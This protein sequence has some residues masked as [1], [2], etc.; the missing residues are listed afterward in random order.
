MKKQFQST[1]LFIIKR[2]I[3]IPLILAYNE[4]VFF[5]FNLK[6]FNIM[7]IFTAIFLG[8]FL[9]LLLNVI[10]KYSKKIAFILI[11]AIICLTTLIYI[12]ESYVHVFFN[13]FMPLDMIF[14]NAI[15]VARNY[16]GDAGAAVK[17]NLYIITFFIIPLFIL[18]IFREKLFVDINIK[19]SFPLLIVTLI[20]VITNG[21]LSKNLISNGNDFYSVLY[22]NGLVNA[23]IFNNNNIDTDFDIQD[24][25][26]DSS[27]KAINGNAHVLG[28]N[29]LDFDFEKIN[30]NAKDNLVVYNNKYVNSLTPSNKN[31]YTG[32][33]KGKNVIMMCAES[34]SSHAVTKELTPTLYRLLHNGF[35]FSNAY[36]T[37]I[38]NSTTEGEF[39]LLTGLGTGYGNV[40][41]EK[42][43]GKNNS[44]TFANFTKRAGYNTACFHNGD[45]YYY[46][47]NVTHENI[48][49]DYF[50]ANNKGLY[51]L[52]HNDGSD[53]AMFDAT[54]DLYMD[55]QP[56]SVYYMTYDGH[57]PYNKL[58]KSYALYS[59]LVKGYYGSDMDEAL[60]SYICK[61][62]SFDR[63]LENMINKLDKK[64]ILNDTVIVFA[65]DHY[66]YGLA[67][68]NVESLHDLYGKSFDDKD[69]DVRDTN[70]IVLWSGSL[71][72]DL[73][74]YQKEIKDPVNSLDILP[75]LLNLFGFE[76]DSRF[77]VGRDV[78][79]DTEAIIFWGNESFMTNNCFYNAINGTTKSLDGKNVDSEYVQQRLKIVQDKLKY[80]KYVLSTDYFKYFFDTEINENKNSAPS[81]F[82]SLYK[83]VKFGKYHDEELEW[84]VLEQ[85]T[86]GKSLLLSKNIV[87]TIPYGNTTWDTSYLRKFANSTFLDAAFNTIEQ[88]RLYKDDNTGDTVFIFSHDDFRKYFSEQ[89]DT[90]PENVLLAA[91]ATKYAISKGLYIKNKSGEWYDGNGS[92]WLR[93][94]TSSESMYNSTIEYNGY[95]NSFGY[96]IDSP[97]VGF[98]PAIWVLLD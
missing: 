34:F 58:G 15:N 33:F 20:I 35:Y 12:T 28:Y 16:A 48:G 41:M 51:Q 76:Y 49:Y 31:E 70:G 85:K 39:Q 44:Y 64:G 87:D 6:T 43:I 2:S 86:G 9:F 68:E 83:V 94:S 52:T 91:G 42:T 46:N 65:A 24:N 69:I 19:I 32:L 3:I 67:K 14:N 21:I 30:E 11:F 13:T 61:E 36:M 23:I 90:T 77:F 96:T 88:S 63:A 82:D 7:A 17:G 50:L 56:F 74:P 1:I 62:V 60:C 55:K 40:C 4:V 10:S 93:D 27:N 84:I 26:I 8:F 38:T 37:T 57:V 25:S 66:P 72:N 97:Y 79:S 80:S 92:Y 98:R 89:I 95:I 81:V 22:K 53:Y 73:K 45:Y 47:R 78:F 75:T 71:E 54:L 18:F 5:A 29:M 59:D